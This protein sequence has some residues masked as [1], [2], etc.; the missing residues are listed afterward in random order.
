VK[1][2]PIS[3]ARILSAA[4]AA[5]FTKVVHPE[6]IR[7]DSRDIPSAHP[8][9]LPY[10]LQAKHVDPVGSFSLGSAI[11]GEDRVLEDGRKGRSKGSVYWVGAANVVYWIDGEKGIVV[12]AAANFFPFMDGKW[13]EFVAGLEGLVYEGLEGE[14]SHVS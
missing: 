14:V 11:Q 13:V 9:F 4:S 8:F 5:E 6:E 7:N 3:G 1:Q 2:E 10:Q 12:V